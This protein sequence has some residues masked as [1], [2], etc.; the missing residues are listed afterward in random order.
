MEIN[1]LLEISKPAQVSPLKEPLT[2]AA[3]YS[4][5]GGG[6]RIRPVMAWVMAVNGSFLHRTVASFPGIYAYGFTDLR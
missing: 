2:D 1:R 6:K 5:A 3:N 4:L